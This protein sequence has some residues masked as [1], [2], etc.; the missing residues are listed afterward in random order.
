MGHSS[1]AG[2]QLLTCELKLTKVKTP[3]MTKASRTVSRITFGASSALH[4]SLG[5][6]IWGLIS[7]PAGLLEGNQGQ[8]GRSGAV[9][10]SSGDMTCLQAPSAVMPFQNG[11]FAA[12][13]VLL[14]ITKIPP[15]D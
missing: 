6:A 8:V 9:Q 3:H 4:V 15:K 7:Q 12:L 10:N 5:S 13:L 2:A 11:N 1:A 14:L